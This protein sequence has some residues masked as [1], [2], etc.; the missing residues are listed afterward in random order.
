M[1]KFFIAVIC[2]IIALL[3]F[4]CARKNNADAPG[5]RLHDIPASTASSDDEN[6]DTE[7]TE[8]EE[9]EDELSENN[10]DRNEETDRAEIKSNLRDARELIEAG[11]LEDAS[12]IIK[13]LQ[14]RH[15]TDAEK[16]ELK[17][18]Q[19]MMITISD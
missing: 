3:M 11:A 4:S 1:K 5:A 17:E 6:T 10:P 15:L 12:M 9:D 7:T 8:C 13:G 14:T 19:K 16:N 2:L 18:L